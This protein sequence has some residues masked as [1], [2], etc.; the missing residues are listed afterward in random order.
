MSFLQRAAVSMSLEVALDIPIFEFGKRRRWDLMHPGGKPRGGEQWPDWILTLLWCGV[1]C[2]GLIWFVLSSPTSP[3]V[4]SLS[5]VSIFQLI[6]SS[7]N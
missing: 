6:I 3:G 5:E 4:V 1:V 7:V 2:F